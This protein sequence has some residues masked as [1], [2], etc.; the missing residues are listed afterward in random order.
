MYHEIDKKIFRKTIKL[1]KNKNID[2][3]LALTRDAAKMESDSLQNYENCQSSFRANQRYMFWIWHHSQHNAIEYVRIKKLN[4][5][6][7]Q[8]KTKYNHGSEYY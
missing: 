7:Q 4:I 1:V 6:R 5:Q 8:P 2:E 3:L